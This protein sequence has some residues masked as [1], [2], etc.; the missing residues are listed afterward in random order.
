MKRTLYLI[1]KKIFKPLFGTSISRIPGVLAIFKF[2]FPLFSPQWVYVQDSKINMDRYDPVSIYAMASNIYGPFMTKLFKRIVKKD[3]VVVDLGAH[4]G[5]YTLLASRLVGENGIV[6]AF[7]PDPKTYSLLL[8]NIQLNQYRNINAIQK[9]ISNNVGTAKLYLSPG[10]SENTLYHINEGGSSIDVGVDTLDHYFQDT[11]KT[12]SVIKMDI[13][14]GE[15]SALLGMERI[16][17]EN[18]DMTI[19]LEFIPDFIRRAGFAPQDLLYK[20]FS[21]KFKIYLIDDKEKR[22]RYSNNPDD[23]ISSCKRLGIVD[24][25][26]MKRQF[27]NQ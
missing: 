10:R 14:G 19:F 8:K 4:I 21:Y 22:L 27:R 7:E 26:A 18:I 3:N 25:V 20:L 5:Y 9:A 15:M 12:I 24:L 16:L 11:N 13:E 6:Y 1:F 17:R 2:F 23:I